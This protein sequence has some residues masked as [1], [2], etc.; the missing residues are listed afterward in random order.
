[1]VAR[2]NALV[3]LTLNYL[4]CCGQDPLPVCVHACLRVVCGCLHSML[5]S[6]VS[7]LAFLV[8]LGFLVAC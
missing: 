1:M 5:E 7:A 6:A 2:P 8:A 4:S 3:V